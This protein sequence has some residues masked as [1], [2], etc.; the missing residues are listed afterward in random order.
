MGGRLPAI[1]DSSFEDGDVDE[2]PS[3]Y[4]NEPPTYF[5]Y[6]RNI[7]A[8]QEWRPRGAGWAILQIVE[9]QIV[10]DILEYV[11]FSLAFEE[12]DSDW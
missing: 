1:P 3:D 5:L 12:L 6:V 2:L 10:A 11:L 7:D 9:L 4:P 8:F